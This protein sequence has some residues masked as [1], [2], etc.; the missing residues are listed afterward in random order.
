RP[1]PPPPILTAF[2]QL[3]VPGEAVTL[4]ARLEPAEGDAPAPRLEGL[5]LFFESGQL[6]D[7]RAL[8]QATTGPDGEATLQWQAPP[9][10][11]PSDFTVRLPGDT[12]QKESIAQ[13][14]VFVFPRDSAVLIVD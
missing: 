14:R 11:R 13:A 9:G 2:D 10:L 8:G 3:A 4:R 12:R 5:E 6:G 7:I 1:A